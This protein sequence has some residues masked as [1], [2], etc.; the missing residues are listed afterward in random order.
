MYMVGGKVPRRHDRHRFSPLC[1]L[2]DWPVRRRHELLVSVKQQSVVEMC[3]RGTAGWATPGETDH[4]A[5]SDEVTREQR[6]NR[7]IEQMARFNTQR[8]GF[9]GSIRSESVPRDPW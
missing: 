1:G 6:S 3:R 9:S 7:G 2:W 8:H 5:A 4:L